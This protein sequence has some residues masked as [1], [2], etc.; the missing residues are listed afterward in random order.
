[1]IKGQNDKMTFL[2][3]KVTFTNTFLRISGK[4]HLAFFAVLEIVHVRGLLP[5]VLAMTFSLEFKIVS[6]LDG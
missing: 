2:K 6:P 5:G 4:S 3:N 1:L